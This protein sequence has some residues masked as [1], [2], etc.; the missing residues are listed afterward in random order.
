MRGC[1][2]GQC[3]IV[4]KIYAAQESLIAPP[5]YGNFAREN[6]TAKSCP[7]ANTWLVERLDKGLKMVYANFVNQLFRTNHLFATIYLIYISRSLKTLLKINIFINIYQY[8]Y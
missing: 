1:T 6:A 3:W 8:I 4:I 2:P 5:I 7:L